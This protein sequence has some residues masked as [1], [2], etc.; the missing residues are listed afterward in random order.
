MGTIHD[1]LAASTSP[2][3]KI[4]FS[5]PYHLLPNL[6]CFNLKDLFIYRDTIPVS[7]LLQVF[8]YGVFYILFALLAAA[9]LFSRK[10][11]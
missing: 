1:Q 9:A 10:E 11:L 7:Y 4:L 8:G 3:L 6:E 2:A 5:I